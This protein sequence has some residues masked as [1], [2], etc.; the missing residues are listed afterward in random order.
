MKTL[1]TLI[2]L[3]L[4][5]LITSA[6]SA[7]TCSKPSNVNIKRSAIYYRVK[8]GSLI[9]LENS[10]NIKVVSTTKKKVT[11]SFGNDSRRYTLSKNKKRASYG[12]VQVSL[13]NGAS[14]DSDFSI[15]VE[16]NPDPKPH[17]CVCFQVCTTE[18]DPVCGEAVD[19]TIRVY[20]N[21]CE[22]TR[23]CAN[24]LEPAL[25]GIEKKDRTF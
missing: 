25:C 17:L 21:L 8:Q 24:I 1:K 13:K 22:A 20:G 18:Y 23:D 15:A 11:I 10:P 14:D 19:G 7:T 5:L 4:S 2:L 3:A 12:N 16:V 9:C 6:V